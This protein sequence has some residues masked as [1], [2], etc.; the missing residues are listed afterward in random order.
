MKRLITLCFCICSVIALNAQTASDYT[1][2]HEFAWY[3]AIPTPFTTS[4]IVAGSD[5]T[6]TGNIP[7]GFT[8]SYCGVDYT[9]VKISANGF[10][11][12]GTTLNQGAF[13]ND[14]AGTTIK[15]VIAPLWDDL[16]VGPSGSVVYSTSG[17]IPNRIFT[18]EFRYMKWWYTAPNENRHFQIRLYETTNV[19][20]FYYDIVDAPVGTTVGAS[21]GISDATG[22]VN[23]FL[24]VTPGT[25]PT[26]S[27]TVSNNLI[28]SAQYLNTTMF[29]FTPA[30]C[31]APTSFVASGITHNGALLSWSSSGITQL[32]YHTTNFNPAT[33]G[34]AINNL[35]SPYMAS[36]LLSNTT[37]YIY[38]Q[39]ECSN[40]ITSSWSGPYTFK[41]LCFPFTAFPMQEGFN[42]MVPPL[43]WSKNIV[44]QTGQAPDWYFTSSGINP[45]ATPYEGNGMACFNSYTC[46][47]GSMAR[48][49]TQFIDLTG[50]QSPVLSYMMYHDNMYDYA[51]TEGVQVQIST[52]GNTWINIGPV[53]VRYKTTV[54]WE[55]AELDLSAYSGQH[56]RIGFLG[57]SQ[58]GNNIF[59]DD[60]QLGSPP[61]CM[62]PATSEFGIIT[63]GTAQV[64]WTQVAGAGSYEY[65]TGIPGFSPGTGNG[66]FTGSLTDTTTLLSSLTPATQYHFFV[67]TDCGTNGLSAW[68][69]P[70]TFST[71]CNP[72]QTMPWTEPFENG[73]VL[74]LCWSVNHNPAYV[75]FTNWQMVTTDSYGA[76]SGYNG[77]GYFARLYTYGAPVTGNPYNLNSAP[78]FIPASYYKLYY[79]YWIKSGNTNPSPIVVKASADYGQTWTTLYSHT[80]SVTNTWA[81]M[82]I[83]LAQFS[84]QNIIIRFEG[85]SNANTT[86]NLGLDHV[87][88]KA[89]KTLVYSGYSFSEHYSNNGSIRDT[90]ALQLITET[91]ATSG[92]MTEG[93]HYTTANIPAGFSPIVEVTSPDTARFLL[94]GM[95][96]SHANSD[97]IGN[98]KL[99]FLDAAFTGGN[100]VSVLQSKVDTFAINFLDFLVINEADA[101]QTG[102]DL[103]EFIELYDGGIGNFPL[104]GYCVVLINGSGDVVYK[105]WDLDGYTTDSNGYFV[106]GTP[107]ISTSTLYFAG[108]TLQNG[109]DAIALF[110]GSA[111]DFPIGSTVTFDKLQDAVVYGNS[112]AAD[113]GLLMMLAPGQPQVEEN[114]YGMGTVYSFQRIPNG[115]GDML[116]TYTFAA[117]P[118]TPGFA[119]APAPVITWP[120][121]TFFESLT[122]DGSIETIVNLLLRND[123]FDVTG[124]LQ[125]NLHYTHLNLPAGL[126]FNLEV[127]N[128]TT[129]EVSITGNALQHS[130]PDN[131][132]NLTLILGSSI[133]RHYTPD[134]IVRAG[135][136]D[137]HIEF[138]YPVSAY[139][140]EYGLLNVYPN[141]TSGWII[142]EKE[143]SESVPCFHLCDIS[144][145]I[146]KVLPHHH[147]VTH[148]DLSEFAPGMYFLKAGTHQAR[149][150][151]K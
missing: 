121:D 50:Q 75:G 33:Q 89:E 30:D 52:D 140:Q 21:I 83:S 129:L 107:N 10:I 35:T 77:S 34:Y 55:V 58:F 135:R 81:Q 82:T 16:M 146:L 8:F 57:M 110:E 76:P 102:S 126:E 95:A 28:N 19:I 11:S 99:E 125:E 56:I 46:S 106:M 79:Y 111:G 23:H 145:R 93:V 142:A 113:N 132:S 100:A 51:N 94:S 86:G 15:P 114:E 6:I 144:G 88:I 1:F 13:T 74:P 97:D 87:E 123:T 47:S 72:I 127:L 85:Y 18:V 36:G 45:T 78:V 61:S 150:I 63:P 90:I 108:N 69:G 26:V 96:N 101:D 24:S 3:P 9:T 117:A 137:M 151:K 32:K 84:G 103:N 68:A 48:L 25:A 112:H 20:E 54:G 40:G 65:E 71:P 120:A 116:H 67:R 92:I 134:L 130:P 39:E 17:S 38:L 138:T 12:P 7:I 98:M 37:Y 136:N 124:L 105:A 2:S 42:N 22:G 31:P 118:P 4:S 109:A 29:R 64:S 128:D 141:P 148:I 27:G 115:S 122:D 59:I 66:L 5:E 139:D 91:F 133:F 149:I 49:A 70:Y 41:T 119:N 73:G 104:D 131:V 80:T 143:P 44:A 62:P 147:Y 60:V 43:C 14:L 53:N